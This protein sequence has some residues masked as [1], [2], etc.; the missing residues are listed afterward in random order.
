MDENMSKAPRLLAVTLAVAGVPGSSVVADTLDYVVEGHCL[1]DCRNV[2]LADGDGFAGSIAVDAAFFT[3]GGF[4]GDDA[5]ETFG[6]AF[7]DFSL[8]GGDLSD[9]VFF[10][11]WRSA[12]GVFR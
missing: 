3:P 8:T 12:P 2:G 10:I 11:D 5:L 4:A 7:G 1:E 6:F 9:P